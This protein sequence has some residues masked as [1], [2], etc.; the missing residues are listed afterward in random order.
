MNSTRRDL[1]R[2]IVIGG[3]VL[4]AGCEWVR[5]PDGKAGFVKIANRSPS[6]HRIEFGPETIY[7]TSYQG[8][9]IDI[10]ADANFHV[11]LFDEPGEYTVH[12]TVDGAVVGEQTVRL[13]RASGDGGLDGPALV[14][15]I[16]TNDEISFHREA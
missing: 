8:R 9:T 15:D 10:Q 16:A 5:K 14:L 12:A 7:S 1:G 2:A 4:V 3:L 6:L 11:R 13:T